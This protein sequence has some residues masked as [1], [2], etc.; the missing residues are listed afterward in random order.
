MSYTATYSPEDN[1]LRLYSSGRLDAETYARVKEAGFS[2][3]PK[4]ELFYAPMWTPHREDLLLEMC[5]EIDDEDRTLVERAEERS[6]RFSEYSDKRAEDADRAHTAVSA[7]ADGIPYGQPILVGHHSERRARKD[8]ERIESGMR[9]AIKMWNTSKYWTDRAAGAVRHAKYKERPDVRA[10]RIKTLEADKRRQER[11]IA[12]SQKFLKAWSREELTEAQARTIANFDHVT[13]YYKKDQ[14]PASTYEGASSIYSGLASGLIDVT[15]A[16]SI[17]IPFHKRVIHGANRWLQHYENRIAYQRAMLGGENGGIIADRTRPEKGGACRCWASPRGG[18]SYIQKVN[19]VSVSIL[20]TYGNGGRSFTRII[21]FDKLAAVMS[22]AEVQEKRDAGCLTESAEG[23]GFFLVKPPLEEPQQEDPEAALRRIWDAKGVSKERQDQLLAE[24]T[25]KAQPGAKVGP[26]T[27][28]GQIEAMR[29][30]LKGG[31]R[32]VSAPQLFP[33]P[34]HLA[35]HMVELAQIEPGHRVLEPSA[36]T[37]VLCK[38]ITAA[39]PTAQ[40]FAVEINSQLCELLSQTI[41]PPEDKAAGICKNVL[42]GDFL[43][44]DGLGNQWDRIVMNPPFADGADIK[45]ISHALKHLKPGGRLVA[46]C[47]NGPR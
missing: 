9:K 26:F 11:T 41:N 35:A 8:A 18:W 29:E 21:P 38:A 5:G 12:E 31:V 43:E 33:T 40:V 2:Y 22:A 30:T 47:A 6:E 42:Q 4:Q 3:A 39:H 14:Y 10:R 27:L 37:G 44:V 24:V 28:G 7:I 32:V 17:C 36:G 34:P 1:K 25:A 15:Q 16:I 13:V 19:K 20:D 46:I 23:I 45:H